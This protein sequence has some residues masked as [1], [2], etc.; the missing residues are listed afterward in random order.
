MLT[1]KNCLVSCLG[2]ELFDCVSYF[3]LPDEQTVRRIFCE[4]LDAVEHC[5]SRPMASCSTHNMHR[6]QR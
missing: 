1:N 2:G 4:L 3:P 5:H 6:V